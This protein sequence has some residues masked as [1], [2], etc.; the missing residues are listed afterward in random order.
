MSLFTKEKG[1]KIIFIWEN[2]HQTVDHKELSLDLIDVADS[3]SFDNS[4]DKEIN[5]GLSKVIE[6]LEKTLPDIVVATMKY[7]ENEHPDILKWAA[8]SK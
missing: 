7:N 1:E 4:E 8:L 6:W 2:N 5:V 3:T